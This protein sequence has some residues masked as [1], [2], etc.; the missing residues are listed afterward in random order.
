MTFI[1]TKFILRVNLNMKHK[2]LIQHTTKIPVS[3]KHAMK[4]IFIDY[5][6]LLS[7]AYLVCILIEIYLTIEMCYQNYH[8]H[9][10]SII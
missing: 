2:I 6:R 9:L 10:I 1:F 4:F 5:L 7:S 8:L 3:N